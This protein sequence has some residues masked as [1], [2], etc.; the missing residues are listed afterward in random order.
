MNALLVATI[1][2]EPNPRN[3]YRTRWVVS[4][5]YPSHED[6]PFIIWRTGNADEAQDAPYSLAEFLGYT[7]DEVEVHH[8]Y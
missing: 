3:A 5:S 4:I 2:T 1:T 8:N 6:D 7:R